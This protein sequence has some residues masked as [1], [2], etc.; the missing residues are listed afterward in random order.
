MLLFVS[1]LFGALDVA[2]S[3][4]LAWDES[5]ISAGQSEF[6]DAISISELKTLHVKRLGDLIEVAGHGGRL[7]VFCGIQA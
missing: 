1:N 3:R 2:H 6:W 5:A 4:G 7:A